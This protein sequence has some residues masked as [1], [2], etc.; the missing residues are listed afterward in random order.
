[1]YARA[2]EAGYGRADY[3]AVIKLLEDQAGAEV[4]TKPQN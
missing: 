3:S 4:R 1:M 2:R